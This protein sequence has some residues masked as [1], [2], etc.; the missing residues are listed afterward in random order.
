M[1]IVLLLSLVIL[2]AQAKTT[3][4]KFTCKD[5][6]NTFCYETYEPVIAFYEDDTFNFY[7]NPCF[8][9]LDKETQ[10]YYKLSPCGEIE[11]SCDEGKGAVCALSTL[12]QLRGYKSNCEACSKEKVKFYFEGACPKGTESP[13][14]VYCKHRSEVELICLTAYEPVCGYNKAGRPKTFGNSCF[15]CSANDIVYYERGACHSY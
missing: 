2:C 6:N 8:A 3:S 15:A 10:F 13:E 14:R 1:K 7:E 9:C 11:E 4:K 5:R 12:G